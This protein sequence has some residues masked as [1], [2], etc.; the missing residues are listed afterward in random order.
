MGIGGNAHAEHG[1]KLGIHETEFFRAPGI[2]IGDAVIE[3]LTEG[4]HRLR[5]SRGC[6]DL[7]VEAEQRSVFVS[8]RKQ[9][10]EQDFRF[11][12]DMLDRIK[13]HGLFNV[14]R[15][16]FRADVNRVVL[17]FKIRIDA[18]LTIA[19]A[20]GF[21]HVDTETVMQAVNDCQLG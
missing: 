6:H 19:D 1:R 21:D 18:C 17:A 4:S 11:L 15:G 13:Q 8:N 20:R 12:L 9:I 2:V 14:H 7:R 16:L 3:L 10:G 5:V